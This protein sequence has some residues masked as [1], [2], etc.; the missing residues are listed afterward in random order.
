LGVYD[1]GFPDKVE[2]MYFL[3]ADD[4]KSIETCAKNLMV[5]Y[6]YRGHKEYFAAYLP[7]IVDVIQDCAGLF[8]KYLITKTDYLKMHSDDQKRY[9][10]NRSTYLKYKTKIGKINKN[11]H[12]NENSR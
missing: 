7:F 9:D 6:A 11:V 10:L 2:V 8:K 1:T 12:D 3:E 4:P 5:H